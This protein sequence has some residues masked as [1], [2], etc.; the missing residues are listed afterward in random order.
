M[1]I[2]LTSS[3]GT[4]TADVV[5][6]ISSG[7]GVTIDGLLVKDNTVNKVAIT[8]PATGATLT[9]PDGVTLTGPAASGTAATLAGTETLSNK[10]LTT[11]NIGAATGTSLAV[12]GAVTSSGGGIGYATGAGG[13]VTQL[14]DATT[15]VTLN[16]LS[17][18]I[19]TV[20]LDQ[21]AGVDFSFTLTNSTIA[22]GDVVV[23]SVKSYGGTA[24]GIPV[25]SVAATGAG[26]C[27]LNVRNTGAVTLDAVAVINFAV[28]KA[29]A[30]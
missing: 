7:V 9:I 4:I 30:A 29:V 8:A 1:A 20:A 25:V 14:T 28:I 11:P 12:T 23:A 2:T 3:T 27:V 17:G 13:A 21:A 18:Q 6:E 26:S 10:T 15:G 5:A 16:K 22:A 19:T 24:D